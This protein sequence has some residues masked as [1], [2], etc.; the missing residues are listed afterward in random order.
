MDNRT[1]TEP[2]VSDEEL[3]R[4]RDA[5]TLTEVQWRNADTLVEK[6]FNFER[7][8]FNAW[9]KA[10]DAFE[11]AGGTKELFRRSIEKEA[12]SNA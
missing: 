12:K 5:A 1:H 9:E 8:K 3:V 2:R 4:L 7:A 11:A 10:K 6:A